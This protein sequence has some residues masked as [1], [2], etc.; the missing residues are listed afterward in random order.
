MPRLVVAKQAA[1]SINTEAEPLLADTTK[2]ADAYES[3]PLRKWTL[4][5][6]DRVRGPRAA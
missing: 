2:L 6:R 1:R 3:N 4:G 5:V